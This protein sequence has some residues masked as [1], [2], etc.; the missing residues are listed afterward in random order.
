MKD[1]RSDEAVARHLQ[2][3]NIL[4]YCPGFE[5]DLSIVGRRTVTHMIGL[6]RH[7]LDQLKLLDVKLVKGGDGGTMGVMVADVE[8]SINTLQNRRVLSSS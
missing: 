5:I 8:W 4:I 2:K 1:N 3:P 7:K 6:S